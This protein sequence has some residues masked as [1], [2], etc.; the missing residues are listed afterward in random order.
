MRGFHKYFKLLAIDLGHPSNF[1][2]SDCI[3]VIK[4]MSLLIMKIDSSNLLL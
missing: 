1:S 4:P 2:E 3:P